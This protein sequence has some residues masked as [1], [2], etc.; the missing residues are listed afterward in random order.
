M[1][2]F[3]HPWSDVPL[4]L[5]SFLSW[6]YLLFFLLGFRLTGPFI[7]I[8]Y[9]ILVEDMSRFA[10]MGMV[11]YCGFAQALYVLSRDNGFGDYFSRVRSLFLTILGEFDF[12]E[13]TSGNYVPFSVFIIVC[14]IFV[15]IVLLNILLAMV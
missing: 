9:E 7:I 14:V 2:M 1:R 10:M 11:F 4:A 5:G 12:D 13:Y 6:M 15:G 3:G 8:M